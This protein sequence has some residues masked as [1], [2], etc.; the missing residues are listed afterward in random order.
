MSHDVSV[1]KVGFNYPIKRGLEYFFS[2]PRQDL[3]LGPHTLLSSEGALSQEDQQQ[4]MNV[5]TPPSGAEVTNAWSYTRP[6]PYIIMPL[7]LIFIFIN[8]LCPEQFL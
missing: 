5:T 3:P 7:C 2:P 4:S 6:S 8:V 1:S